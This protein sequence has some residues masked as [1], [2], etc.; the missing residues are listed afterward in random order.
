[1]RLLHV[2]SG[3]GFGG[4][5]S[6]CFQLI[7]NA[8]SDTENFLVSLNSNYAEMLPCFQNFVCKE[9]IFICHYQS[10]NK[11][12]FILKLW[13]LLL[14][15]KPTTILVQPF[16][17]HI[18]V[19]VAAR[20][21]GVPRILT[22]AGN[23]APQDSHLRQ[24]WK[25]IIQLSRWLNVPIHACSTSTHQSLQALASLPEGSFPIPNGCDVLA[26]RARVKAVRQLRPSSSKTVIGMIARLNPIKDQTTLIHAFQ[27]LHQDFP[28]TE[29]W[30]VGD[31]ADRARLE[32]L[33]QRMQVSNEVKFWG[34]RSDIPELLGKMDIYAFS[35][36]EAEGFGIALIEAMA[37]ALP[38]VA[39]DV[40]ACRE[41]LDN[42]GVGILVPPQDA[43]A[44][45]KA[46][47]ILLLSSDQR[48]RWGQLAYHR[49]VEHYSIQT[50]AQRW[51]DCLLPSEERV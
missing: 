32:Q 45:A 41:V 47:E 4:N 24:K 8:P 37:A 6:I 13:R 38:V 36:T 33:C 27:I 14:A 20:L 10:R 18:F 48:Q 43:N 30:L 29:L 34:S 17:L 9:N 31:G 21:A 26:I 28:N 39:S 15:V 5:E 3:L 11:L 50:C 19:A 40:P 22:R 2:V 16:G 42:G 35:T 46:L 51:Y 12:W 25:R 7:K 1:M 49:A 23:P 44:M